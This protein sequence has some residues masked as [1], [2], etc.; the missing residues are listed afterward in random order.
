M[1]KS[2]LQIKDKNGGNDK[3]NNAER[4][5]ELREVHAYAKVIRWFNQVGKEYH[6]E[7]D[8]DQGNDCKSSQP[9]IE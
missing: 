1:I 7:N 8:P 9:V 4:K 2:R 6:S 3:S 5:S